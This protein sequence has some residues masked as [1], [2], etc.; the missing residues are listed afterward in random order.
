MY[1]QPPSGVLHESVSEHY[2]HL[3]DSLR[4]CVEVDGGSSK[5]GKVLET[6]GGTC[7]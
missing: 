4:F 2:R 7:Y 6:C 1:T 3:L 5:Q